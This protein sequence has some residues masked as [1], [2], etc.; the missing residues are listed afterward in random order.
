[1]IKCQIPFPPSSNH[2]YVNVPGKGRVK[3]EGYKAWTTEALWSLKMQ[4]IKPV[5][6]E[7]SISI[8]LVAPTKH[9]MDCD[10]RIKPAL[11]ILKSAGIIKDDNSKY[12]R[13]VSAEWLATGDPCTVLISEY[14]G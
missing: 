5:L 11:D 9:A 12:V 13:R 1:M 2:M 3:S 6:G 4:G 10:N 8:G 7:V 14:E